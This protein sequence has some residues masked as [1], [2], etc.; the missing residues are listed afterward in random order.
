MTAPAIPPQPDDDGFVD[1]T[2]TADRPCPYPACWHNHPG[3]E[4]PWLSPA[5]PDGRGAS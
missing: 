4:S 5:A 3:E 1:I 2:F